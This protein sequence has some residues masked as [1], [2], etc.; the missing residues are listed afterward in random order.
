MEEASALANQV[1]ILAT[2]ML[3]VGTPSDL[4]ARHGAYEVQ[5][6]CRTKDDSL[7]AHAT[8]AHVPHACLADD[9]ATRFEVP[10]RTGRSSADAGLTGSITLAQLFAV[11][12]GTGLE[13]T[14]ERPSLE[15]VFL[16]VIREHNIAE[17]Q[18]QAASSGG[19]WTSLNA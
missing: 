16:K 12:S 2:S 1:G 13:F 5:F 18:E 15:S 10:I 6:S 4:T 8:M 14:V 19:W 7:R 11:L 3:A 17:E 9:V